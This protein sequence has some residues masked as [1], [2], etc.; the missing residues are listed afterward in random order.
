MGIPRNIQQYTSKIKRTHPGSNILQ[1]IIHLTGSRPRD[2]TE[3]CFGTTKSPFPNG[4]SVGLM[5]IST[6]IWVDCCLENIENYCGEY[7]F[8]LIPLKD[9]QQLYLSPW[10]HFLYGN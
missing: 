8:E 9:L 2:A 1:P 6:I 4:K 3:T 10:A 5:R 7:I